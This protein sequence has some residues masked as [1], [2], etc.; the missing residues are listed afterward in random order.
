MKLIKYENSPQFL[1][2]ASIWTGST[3]QGITIWNTGLS[4][5]KTLDDVKEVSCITQVDHLVWCGSMD[6]TI[7]IY[8]H[9]EHCKVAK[10]DTPSPVR[11]MELVD[12]IMWVCTDYSIVRYDVN[13]FDVVDE[14][15]PIGRVNSLVYI[16]PKSQIWGASSDHSIYIFSSDVGT[17]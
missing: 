11:F 5:I 13:T 4:K 10:I 6:G 9:V 8:H 12:T 1:E 14:P 7:T 2:S 15:I 16:Q 17:T 3:Y